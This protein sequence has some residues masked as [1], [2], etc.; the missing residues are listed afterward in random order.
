VLTSLKLS[1]IPVLYERYKQFQTLI[2]HSR[3]V[4][5][6]NCRK[7]D[8]AFNRFD[9]HNGEQVGNNDGNDSRNGN[10]NNH[11]DSSSE[12]NGSDSDNYNDHDG[13]MQEAAERGDEI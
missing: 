6:S 13:V 10:R 5:D 3:E 12:D 7:I 9:D 1:I 8:E 11:D 4:I 2:L